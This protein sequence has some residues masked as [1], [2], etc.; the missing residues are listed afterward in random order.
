MPMK[1]WVAERNETHDWEADKVL[2]GVY[3]QSRVITTE[4]GDS[5][6]YTVDKGGGKLVDVWGKAMLD[7]FFKN[8]PVGSMIEVTYKGK[9]KSKKGGRTYHNFDFS[10]DSDTAVA[11]P[12]KDIADVA[13]EIMNS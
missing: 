9:E 13:E 1:K 5:N 6:M 11:T 4:N 7:S 8:I 12:D 10:Y 2:K 3:M